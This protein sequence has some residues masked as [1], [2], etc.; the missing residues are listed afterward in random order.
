MNGFKVFWSFSFV[1]AERPC[2]I[3]FDNLQV[4]LFYT[5][6]ENTG[7]SVRYRI[8]ATVGFSVM[9]EDVINDAVL[10]AV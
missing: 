10:M 1:N 6:V 9:F 5:A 7:E 2:D 4:N 3:S 8:C